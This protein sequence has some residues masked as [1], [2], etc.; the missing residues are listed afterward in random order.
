MCVCVC[1]WAVRLIDCLFVNQVEFG[2]HAGLHACGWGG[3]ID[4]ID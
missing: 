1:V 3:L 4:L 2:K